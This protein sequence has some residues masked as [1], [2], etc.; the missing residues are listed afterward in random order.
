M[1]GYA[2]AIA[3]FVKFSPESKIENC[4]DYLKFKSNFSKDEKDE[5]VLY[6]RNYG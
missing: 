3:D 6:K 5:K 2:Q 1:L 4:I